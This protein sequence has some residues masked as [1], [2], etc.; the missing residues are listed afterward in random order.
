VTGVLL[1]VTAVVST[2]LVWA[3]HSSGMTLWGYGNR[4]VPAVRETAPGE[5]DVV[6]LPALVVKA[7]VLD[8]VGLGERTDQVA[9]GGSFGYACGP[10]G[11]GGRIQSGGWFQ[12]EEGLVVVEVAAVGAGLGAVSLERVRDRYVECPNV[13]VRGAGGGVGGGF[14]ADDG[15]VVEH[16]L[17]RGDVLV[18]VAGG[19]R[20]GRVGG[21]VGRVDAALDIA[22][23]PVCSDTSAGVEAAERN[24]IWPRYSGLL[25][26]REVRMGAQ[27]DP[28]IPAVTVPVQPDFT[29]V[30]DDPA[31]VPS[32]VGPVIDEAP[33]AVG[34][35]PEVPVQEL[36]LVKVLDEVG[37]GCG[38]AF[39]GTVAPVESGDALGA[40]AKLARDRARER[41]ELRRLGA[42]IERER[43]VQRQVNYLTE[44][45]AYESYRQR[46]AAVRYATDRWR[47]T[48]TTTVPV[49]TTTVPVTT[50][51]TTTVPVTTTTTTTTTVPVPVTTT[52]VPAADD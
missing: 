7:A 2:S 38:W 41:L 45:A 8:A 18:R 48:T 13:Q 10:I 22:L 30:V 36:Y 23:G 20:D 11:L 4:L 50:T 42:Q 49:T 29:Q 39:A 15:T 21:V 52:T 24:P 27:G 32:L 28:V 31:F 46:E 3:L 43:W 1:A 40:D 16:V 37:P 17:R 44:V 6:V 5:A 51:T 26:Q 19:V 14:R 34:P 9:G 25:A 12:S 35:A 33:E 47:S